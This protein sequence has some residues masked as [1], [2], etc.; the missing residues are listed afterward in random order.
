MADVDDTADSHSQNGSVD[1]PELEAEGL[2]TGKF[3]TEAAL[4]RMRMRLLDL[5]ANNR[6]L[7]YRFA[8]GR[9]LRVI[10]TPPA[11]LFERLYINSKDVPIL[12]VPDPPKELYED[13]EGVL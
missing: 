7:N 9:A 8:R 3:S 4:E 11:E 12:P 10:D 13:H 2:F 5:S 6:L 1:T